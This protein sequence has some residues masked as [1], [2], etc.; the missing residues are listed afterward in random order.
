MAMKPHPPEDMPRAVSLTEARG[1][2]RMD[3]ATKADPKS[4][5]RMTIDGKIVSL[6]TALSYVS[7]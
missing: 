5:A 7:K 6:I 4:T 2:K 3:V 1:A